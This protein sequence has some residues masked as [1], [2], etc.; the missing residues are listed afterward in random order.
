MNE[1]YE[2]SLEDQ[3]LIKKMLNQNILISIYNQT[4]HD[5]RT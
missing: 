5:L 3:E 1:Q 2:I 4:T